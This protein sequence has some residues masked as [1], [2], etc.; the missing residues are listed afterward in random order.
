MLY[1]NLQRNITGK[2][3]NEWII[4]GWLILQF[5]PVNFLIFIKFKNPKIEQDEPTTKKSKPKKKKK[6]KTN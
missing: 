6:K 1:V 5:N 4:I 2:T 3:S